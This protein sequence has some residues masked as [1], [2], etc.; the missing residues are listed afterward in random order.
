[1]L[2]AAFL[3]NPNNASHPAYLGEWKA[4]APAL[5]VQMLFVA[6]RKTR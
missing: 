4:V 2:R 5:G 3:W 1:M 6:V